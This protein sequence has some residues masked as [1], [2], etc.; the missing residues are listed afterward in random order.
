MHLLLLGA[1]SGP[2]ELRRFLR[3]AQ[4]FALYQRDRSRSAKA[5]Q[6]T[7]SRRLFFPIPNKKLVV[8]SATLVVTGALLVVTMFATRSKVHRF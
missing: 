3:N 8:T 7:V 1:L 5:V 2:L 4:G 6:V